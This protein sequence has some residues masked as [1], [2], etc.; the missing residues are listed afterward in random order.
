[1]SGGAPRTPTQRVFFALWPRAAERCALTAASA[2]A[3]AASGGRPVPPQNL[4][5]TLLFLG[6]VS[7]ARGAELAA[8]VHATA[9]AWPADAGPPVLRFARLAYWRESQVLCALARRGDDAG[10]RA[11]AQTLG[12]AAAAAGFSPDLKPF[13]VHVT[14]ARKVARAPG[15]TRFVPVTW[16]CATLALIASRS[17]PGGSVYS[18]LESALLGKREK[19][20]KER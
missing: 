7:A 20:R 15:A 3:V 2:A 16:E 8:L 5:V 12:T 10:A 18:V 19:F 6:A 1:M 9:A 13:R 17:A 11:L 14:V 4:H